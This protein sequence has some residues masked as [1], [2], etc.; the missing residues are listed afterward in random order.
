VLRSVA[1]IVLEHMIWV[2]IPVDQ[3][4]GKMLTTHL[5]DESRLNLIKLLSARL[6]SN[7]L[8]KASAITDTFDELRRS[9]NQ[10]IHNV[11][12]GEPKDL[13]IGYKTS[14]KGQVRLNESYW[15]E[16]DMRG[17]AQDI[18]DWTVDTMNFLNDELWWPALSL[19]FF[20]Q[21]LLEKTRGDQGIQ[22]DNE[23]N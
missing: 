18:S 5:Q 21:L 1:Q 9:R 6:P 13:A 2:L 23:A 10:I 7:L 20:E 14:A 8:T 16:A 15:S 11:W 22:P 4:I 19:K 17:V 3:E 12:S